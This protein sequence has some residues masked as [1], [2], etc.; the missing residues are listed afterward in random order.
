MP[1]GATPIPDIVRVLDKFK[2]VNRENGKKKELPELAFIAADVLG[3]EKPPVKST[4]SR[5]IEK[6]TEYRRQAAAIKESSKF[7][8]WR[9]SKKIKNLQDPETFDFTEKLFRHYVD[10]YSG[11]NLN[12]SIMVG[13]AKILAADYENLKILG[14]PAQSKINQAFIADLCRKKGW[15]FKRV[16]GT[17]KIVPEAVITGASNE[18]KPILDKFKS[19]EIINCDESR[20][21]TNFTGAYSFQPS[22]QED[23]PARKINDLNGKHGL[24]IMQ[25]IC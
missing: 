21:M 4:I 6:E 9:K 2:S 10:L 12:L 1:G 8:R 5:W 15:S 13:E 3:R 11:M 18:M 24:T 20:I 14:R 23:V 17:K 7:D 16:L 19:S 22:A 25:P